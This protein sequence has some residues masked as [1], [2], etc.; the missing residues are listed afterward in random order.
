M[1]IEHTCQNDTNCFKRYRH[2]PFKFP[3]VLSRSYTEYPCFYI[4][5]SEISI[6]RKIY[7]ILSTFA[8]L[9]HT[10]DSVICLIA[11]ITLIFTGIR[12]TPFNVF[13]MVGLLS[14]NRRSLVYGLTDGMQLIADC[15]ASLERIEGFLLIEELYENGK[16]DKEREEKPGNEDSEERKE[17]AEE[18]EEEEESSKKPFLKVRYFNAICLFTNVFRYRYMY[19]YIQNAFAL[20]IAFNISFSKLRSEIVGHRLCFNNRPF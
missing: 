5:R 13:T 2:Y 19:I 10:Y 16:E 15:F 7:N 18:E 9:Q 4:Y 20:A 6:L 11:F 3:L 12:L 8:S 17:E 14:E 1:E